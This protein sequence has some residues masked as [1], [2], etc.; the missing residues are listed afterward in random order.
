[1][2][3]DRPNVLLITVDSLRARN[4]SAYG[5]GRE[6]TPAFDRLSAEAILFEKAFSCGPCTPL[7]FP[8]ILSGRYVLS[9]RSLGAFD[10]PV[11]LA[12]VFQRAGYR[13]AA[14][15]AANPWISHFYGWNR[16]FD[17]FHEYLEARPGDTVHGA[18]MKPGTSGAASRIDRFAAW[19]RRFVPR[20]SP[21]FRWGVASKLFLK[22]HVLARRTI[23]SKLELRDSFFPG[24]GHWLESLE[25]DRPFFLWVHDMEVHYPY[26]PTAEA[27]RALGIKVPPDWRQINLGAL[28]QYDLMA[29][30]I[31]V[32]L[33]RD[34]YDGAVRTFDAY[35]DELF[36]RLDRTGLRD[37]TVILL[38]AD[39]GEEFREH[40]GFQHQA[41]LYEE[42]LHVPLALWPLSGE[43]GRYRDVVSLID[44]PTT[45]VE[46]AGLEVPKSFA[47]QPLPRRVSPPTD[48][49]PR[50]AISEACNES[51]PMAPVRDE[52]WKIQ[53]LKHRYGIR[54]G[55]WRYTMEAHLDRGPT[56][57]DLEEDPGE[58]SNVAGAH[59]DLSRTL[60]D[61]L[62]VHRK[63][64]QRTLILRSA[65]S[66]ARPG[67]EP[68]GTAG[69]PA[70]TES[71]H[72]RGE[73]P[74]E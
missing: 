37:S 16:G 28:I 69:K 58:R 59:P 54:L 43:S 17:E 6:T 1:M 45:L 55:R 34:L 70:T 71:S 53:K 30:R 52:V 7:S 63:R 46:A 25:R 49:K 66:G 68:P 35:L 60:D 2:K 18:R 48:P 12:E 4:L 61:L 14:F 67:D 41:K 9:G 27:E 32:D 44:V 26:L 64:N 10:A 74:S 31:P 72:S 13:T 47:G 29:N 23:R 42:L 33:V 65:G 57:F 15:I 21:L 11:T 22:G 38:A 19:A 50:Y 40:G 73:E 5:Y 8:S 56:L 20:N 24:I 39:H 62:R 3:P 51:S 36:R